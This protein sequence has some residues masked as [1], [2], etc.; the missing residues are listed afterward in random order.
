MIRNLTKKSVLSY[1]PFYATNI[2]QRG[3]GL[4]GRG[5]DGFDAIIFEK[6]TAIHTFFMK[7][8][9]DVIFV[10]KENNICDLCNSVSTWK[11]IVKGKNGAFSV[12]EVPENTIF[13][14]N[15]EIGDKIDLKSELNDDI[16]INNLKDK[17]KDIALAVLLKKEK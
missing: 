14:Q 7:I 2:L 17:H 11:P 8:K 13:K 9:I 1:K 3:R 4:I 16:L 15:I 5:F 12:I 6:C 10:D